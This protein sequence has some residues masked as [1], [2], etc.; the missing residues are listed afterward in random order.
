MH[1]E[2]YPSAIAES[3]RFC[4][5][6]QDAYTLRCTPQVKTATN[7]KKT[8]KLYIDSFKVHG[9]CHDTIEFVQRIIT[10]EMNSATDNPIVLPE[11]GEVF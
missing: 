7:S 11:R 9:I 3:H 10:T 4:D 6:V 8:I 2:A 5:R 1:S